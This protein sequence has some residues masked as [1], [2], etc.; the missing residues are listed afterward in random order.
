MDFLIRY[1]ARLEGKLAKGGDAAMLESG[2]R[3]V[4]AQAAADLGDASSAGQMLDA[5]VSYA[6]R[7]RGTQLT[8]VQTDTLVQVAATVRAA[9]IR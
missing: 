9:G 6:S 3:P 2:T 5:Y 1:E 8:A 7:L 4:G